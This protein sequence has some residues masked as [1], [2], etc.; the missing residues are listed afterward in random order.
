[1]RSAHWRRC[2]QP[3]QCLLRGP[4]FQQDR[5]RSSRKSAPLASA[6]AGSSRH[7]PGSRRRKMNRATLHARLGGGLAPAPAAGVQM[8]PEPLCR[9]AIVRG[10][11]RVREPVQQADRRRQT[12][13][14]ERGQQ[15]REVGLA[16]RDPPQA[17]GQAG[18]LDRVRRSTARCS[19][20]MS[21]I[22]PSGLLLEQ[23]V[24]R[25]HPFFHGRDGNEVEDRRA[26]RLQAERASALEGL[27]RL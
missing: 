8:H 16:R 2:V 24:Q 12:A 27:G 20:A 6:R 17:F 4:S 10:M 22:R 26:A 18:R 9:H 1:M 3:A 13:G 15:H 21:A 14:A 25:R 11:P 19:R 23:A 7:E 5:P